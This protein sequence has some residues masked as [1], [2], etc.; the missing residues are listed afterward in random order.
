MDWMYLFYFALAVLFFFGAE[1]VGRGKWHED[2]TSLRQTKMLLG[3]AAVCI[4]LHHMGQKTCAPWHPSKYI[5]HGMDVFVPMGYMLVG[6]FLF[7]SGLGLYR[8][9]KSKPDYLKGFCRRRILPIIVAFYLS[10]FIHTG[11][12]LAMGEKMSVSQVLW[13]LSGLRM[14][15]NNA[16]YVIVIPFFY[17]AFWAAFRFC[18]REGT[19]LFLV[20]A[21]TL[22][23][24]VFGSLIDHQNVWWMRGE[25]WYNSIIMFP[26]GL[27]FGKYERRAAAF[28]R[29]GYWFWLLLSFAGIFLL[30]R[31]SEW[32]NGHLWGYYGE[33]GDP[34]K[35][36]HRLMSAGME[37]LV[38]V[39]FT[40]FCFL[41][42]MKVKLGN[43]V[44]AWFGGMT[45]GFYL[46]HGAFVE[47]F[48]YNFLDITE[49]IVYIRNV[50]LYILVVLA[51]SIPAAIGFRFILRQITLPLMKKAE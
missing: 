46:M 14:A 36:P 20:F 26:L 30:F 42:M 32:L 18:R 4:S 15:N 33:W 38:C 25:W 51:C 43:R 6:L 37:W 44:L 23:Y 3:T 17:L 41:L 9:L 35:V 24:T 39:S 22:A 48:G 7:S 28:L 16:W 27:L 13:Y 2:F 45:L 40:A 8:S 34:L 12:R 11:I 5:V 47:M 19:A 10:E 49:S 1:S 31:Q 29:R 21:F 50:P